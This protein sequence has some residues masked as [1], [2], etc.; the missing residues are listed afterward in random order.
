MFKVE[1]QLYLP[2]YDFIKEGHMKIAT[3]VDCL[4]VAVTVSNMTNYKY[5]DR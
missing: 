3:T 1:N 2:H 4:K 5:K